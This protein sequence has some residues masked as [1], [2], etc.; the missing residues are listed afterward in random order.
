MALVHSH[1]QRQSPPT[2]YWTRD[3]FGYRNLS[4][5]GLGL[6]LLATSVLY[7]RLSPKLL[8]A[9]GPEQVQ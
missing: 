2:D 6:L 3:E 1:G 9:R 7:G 4:F 5:L 8:Q